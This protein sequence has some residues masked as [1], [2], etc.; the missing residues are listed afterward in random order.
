MRLRFQLA[1][2]HRSQLQIVVSSTA[3]LLL[4]LVSASPSASAQGCSGTTGDAKFVLRGNYFRYGFFGKGATVGTFGPVEDDFDNGLYSFPGST[5]NRLIES[6]IQ[7]TSAGGTLSVSLMNRSYLLALQSAGNDWGGGFDLFID[8]YVKGA[9]GSPYDLQQNLSGAASADH[10]GGAGTTHANMLGTTAVVNNGTGLQVLPVSKMSQSSG[11]T[12]NQLHP[13]FSEYSF[14]TTVAISSYDFTYQSINICFPCK[15]FD[16]EGLSTLTGTIVAGCPG[17]CGSAGTTY[18]TAGTSASGCQARLSAT[19]VA[20]ATAA[21]GFDLLAC[22]VEAAKNGI[23]FFGTNGRQAKPWGNGTSFQC[24][25]PP[26]RRAGSL[27]GTGAPG[28]CGGSFLQDLN[29]LWCP[30]CPKPGHNPGAGATV[31]AQLWYRDPLNTSNQT[32]SLSDA[33]E[34]PV[35]P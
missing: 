13:T 14:A 15:T 18:C 6:D 26:V 35:G 1:T 17:G 29:A 10:G 32:T 7:L 23:Y 21:S 16:Y 4:G 33:I 19:G 28:T 2:K 3:L 11:V 12:T 20:S 8:V 9:P 5:T 34:F 30:G 27:T 24:V 31:Q 22:N 25:A